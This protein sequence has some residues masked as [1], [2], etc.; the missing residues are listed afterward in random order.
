MDITDDE[1]LDLYTN[2]VRRKRDAEHDYYKYS[3]LLESR[4]LTVV[5]TS[6][7]D[8]DVRFVFVEQ[9]L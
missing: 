1:L 6:V 7:I 3:S 4:R 9:Y 2:A 8:G 5:D